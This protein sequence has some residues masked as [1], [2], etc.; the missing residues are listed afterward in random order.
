MPRFIKLA[1]LQPLTMAPGPLSDHSKLESAKRLLALFHFPFPLL[2]IAENE[3]C[4]ALVVEG[5]VI[6][7]VFIEGADDALA[8]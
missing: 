2:Q 6:Q 4:T 3:I 1:S 8:S 5:A 7:C